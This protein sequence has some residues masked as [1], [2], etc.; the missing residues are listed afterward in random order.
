[1]YRLY[2]NHLKIPERLTFDRR[3]YDLEEFLLV[4]NNIPLNMNFVKIEAFEKFIERL[5]C[6]NSKDF[7]VPSTLA[8]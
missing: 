3:I 4:A 1:M 7:F 5:W 6:G 8:I 2:S